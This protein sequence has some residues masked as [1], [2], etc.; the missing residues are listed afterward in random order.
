VLEKA[1]IGDDDL[2]LLASRLR[3]LP[4]LE[5]LNLRVRSSAVSSELSVDLVLVH[6]KM[7][8]DSG[9]EPHSDG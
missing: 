1:G 3:Y 6:V 9:C 4:S 7:C 8:M 5:M 2:M